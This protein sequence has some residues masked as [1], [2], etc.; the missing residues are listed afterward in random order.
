[1][2]NVEQFNLLLHARGNHVARWVKCCAKQKGILGFCLGLL[3]KNLKIDGNLAHAVCIVKN[4]DHL[5][6]LRE[7]HYDWALQAKTY[8]LNRPGVETISKQLVL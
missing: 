8:T 7:G 3:V 4:L 5:V 6:F 1:M 2:H